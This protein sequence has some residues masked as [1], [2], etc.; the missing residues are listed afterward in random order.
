[1]PEKVSK[2]PLTLRSLPPGTSG[3]Q[4]ISAPA[5]RNDA[6]GIGGVGL[7]FFA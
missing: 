3:N 4:H 5:N 6:L 7:D 1:M 2:T